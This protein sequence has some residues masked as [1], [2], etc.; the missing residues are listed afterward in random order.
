MT[1]WIVE[2]REPLLV[3]DGRPFDPQPS[4]IAATLPFPFPSTTAG[5]ARS[6]AGTQDGVFK[7]NIDA[8]R[9]IQV[10]G[11]LL[12]EMD[13]DEHWQLLVPAPGDALLLKG[14]DDQPP[15]WKQLVPLKILAGA[16]ARPFGND[17]KGEEKLELVG[18]ANPALDKPEQNPPAFWYWDRFMQWLLHPEQLI[19]S[20]AEKSPGIP[21][22]PQQQRVHIALETGMM[23]AR[24]GALFETHA[25][26]FTSRPGN[27]K[28][29]AGKGDDTEEEKDRLHARRLALWLDVKEHKDYEIRPGLDSLGGE[30]RLVSWQQ[31]KPEMMPECPAELP[32]QIVEQIVTDGACRLIL[33]T[34]ACFRQGYRP[35]LAGWE[36]AGVQP[37]LRA[38]L[39]QRPQVISGW[40]LA[41]GKRKPTRRLAPAGSVFFLKL[42]GRPAERRAWI[43]HTWMNCVSDEL[44]DRRDGFGLAVLGTW[45]GALAEIYTDKGR[46]EQ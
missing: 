14:K 20:L 23:V 27:E 22:L 32:E 19:P 35:D 17:D 11:P 8:L 26:E 41:R 38:A 7:G 2:P 40:D 13:E 33:L 5:A 28:G 30:R 25:L 18:Q 39:V 43:E 12:V 37:K 29:H 45:N 15:L 1:V 6:R 3:R 36:H 9:R 34:P 42:P 44:Q 24:E 16:T 4:V 31:G 10:C 46:R 21:S